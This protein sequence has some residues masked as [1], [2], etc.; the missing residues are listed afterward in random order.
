MVF[1][2][3]YRIIKFAFQNVYRNIWLSLVTITIMILA[4]LSVNFLLF[5]NVLG[6]ELIAMAQDKVNIQIYFKTEATDAEVHAAEADLLELA[7]VTNVRFVGKDEALGQFV[8]KHQG[9]VISRALD[10]LDRNPLGNALYVKSD[11]LDAYP[12]ILKHIEQAKYQKLV[13]QEK[14][15]DHEALI[16]KINTMSGTAKKVGLFMSLIFAVIVVLVVFNT[17]RIAIY[18]HGEE[19]GIMKLVGASNW[20]VRM[21]FIVEGLVFA[22]IATLIVTVIMFPLLGALQP[23]IETFFEG[24]FSML[25]YYASNLPGILMWEFIGASLLNIVASSIAIGKYLKV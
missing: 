3:A 24:T 25:A 15:I 12:S 16:A 1:V 14:L 21:P 13:K 6:T 4:L 20:F 2:T 23:Y 5:L 8:S 19:I 18:T 9:G 10:E 22:W 11:S 7:E 17:I